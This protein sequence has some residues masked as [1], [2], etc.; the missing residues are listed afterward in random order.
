M[1]L[2]RSHI[3]LC[4][5]KLLFG[6]LGFSVECTN[7]VY[8]ESCVDVLFTVIWRDNFVILGVAVSAPNILCLTPLGLFEPGAQC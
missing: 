1:V 3:K 6:G 5:L 7:C 2:F 8:V 4:L